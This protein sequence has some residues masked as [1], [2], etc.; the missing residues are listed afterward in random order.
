MPELTTTRMYYAI[1]K[2]HAGNVCENSGEEVKS[3]KMEKHA[4]E[5]GKEK[6]EVDLRHEYLCSRQLHLRIC[7][8]I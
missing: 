7:N 1:V 4:K 3:K 5:S 8:Y 6:E 2:H